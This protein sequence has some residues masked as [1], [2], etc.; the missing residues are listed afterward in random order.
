M[1]GMM[2]IHPAKIARLCGGGRIGHT[3]VLFESVGSTNSAASRMAGSGRTRR[4][5]RRRRQ[6]DGRTGTEGPRLVF[7]PGRLPDIL[8]DHAPA[9]AARH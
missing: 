6:A 7:E 1:A 3:V 5:R 4:N 2:D 8:G 9:E